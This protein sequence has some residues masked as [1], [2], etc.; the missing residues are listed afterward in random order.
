MS[1]PQLGRSALLRQ[2]P[3]LRGLD[4]TTLDALARAAR[5][6][7]YPAGAVILVEGDPCPGLWVV[8]SGRV[9]A[10][11]LSPSGRE[12]I[13]AI[14][15][16][17][18][19]INEL[20][21]F[22]GA[23]SPVTLQTLVETHL[24]VISCPVFQKLLDEHPEVVREAVKQLARHSRQLVATIADLS[25]RT[26]TARLA[27]LLLDSAAQSH[28]AI[29]T[30]SQMAARLGTVREVVSRAL[31]DLER[32]GLIRIERERIILLKP[33]ALAQLAERE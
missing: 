11:L 23:S 22:D 25:L 10:S 31:R 9:K 17:G 32:L 8:E 19:V 26:V 29:M 1:V 18:D 3:Y 24:A 30:R 21:A 14:Y 20:S 7:H 27:G 2:I 4:E 28:D 16:P 13:L 6:Q 5:T 33:H 12:H 15:G